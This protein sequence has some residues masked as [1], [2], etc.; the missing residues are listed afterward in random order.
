MSRSKKRVTEPVRIPRISSLEEGQRSSGPDV[1]AAVGT[2][3][4]AASP[5][6]SMSSPSSGEGDEDQAT[7]SRF[8]TPP[9]TSYTLGI[10]LNKVHWHMKQAW[11]LGAD[12]EVIAARQAFDDIA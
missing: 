11:L 2:P 1:P 6:R 9:E 10:N 12:V 5:Q 4:A 3:A 8:E 7:R